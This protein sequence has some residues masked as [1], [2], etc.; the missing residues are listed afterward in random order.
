MGVFRRM[1]A[2]GNR[3]KLGREI[4]D[5]LREHMRMRVDRDVASG[6]SPDEAIRRARLRF[7]NPTVV[8]ERVNAEDAAL[9]LDSFFRD[10]RYAVRGFV[11]SPGFTIVAVLTLALG[12]G[13]NTAVFQL[14]DAVRLRSLP[15]QNPKELVE[16]RIVGGN[17]GFGIND[18]MFSNFTIPMWQ[19]VRRHHDPFSDIAA[20]RATDVLAGKLTDGKRV[21]GLEVSGDF[22]NLLGVAP[23]QGRLIEPQDE[24]GCE[25]SGVVVSYP[26]WKSQ[27][28]GQAI[29]PKTT[30]IMD[31]RTVQVL[32]VTQP[33]FFGL[34]V[35]DSFDIAFPT[36]TPPNP[37]REVFF[38]GVMG[39]LKPGWTMDRAS[40]YFGSLSSGIFEETVPTGYDA[41]AVKLYK[42]FRLGAY[43]AGGG[44]SYLRDAYDSSLQLLLA[45][46]GLVLLIACANLANLML[47]RASARQR[48]MAIRMA[49][50][51]SRARLLRQLLIGSSL[52]AISGAAIG[53]ALAQPLSR[54]LIASLNTSQSAIHLSIV[55]D[56]RVLLFAAAV[57]MLTCVVFGT[58]PA[59]RGT[60]VDPIASLKS[61]ERGVAGGR[62]RFSVQRF[63]VVTQIAVS[64]VLLVG[65]LLFVRSYRNLLTL[66]PGMRESG[67]TVGY[68]NYYSMNIKQE[69]EA[70]FKRQLVED[71]RSVPGVENVAA[72]TNVP[73]SGST[74]SHGVRVDGVEGGSRFTY[75]SPSYFATMGIPIVTGRGFTAMDTT[76]AP[77]VLI[78]N[79][80]FAQK[81]FAKT[82]PLGR[83]VQVMPEPQYPART[84]EVVGTIPDTKYNGLR[85][86]PEPI[87]FVPMDQLP[88]TAQGPGVGMMIATQDGPAAIAAVR[89]A[90]AAKYPDMVLQFFN[91][92]QGIRDN[93]VG[94]RMMAMLSGFFGV[95][96]ALLVVI[97]L[98]GVLSYFITQRR[99]EIG[100]R[101]A[102]GADRGR[103]VGLV[104]RDTAAMLA[105]GLVLGT[106]LALVAGRGASSM[107]FGLQAYDAA[108]LTFAALLLAAIAVLASLLPA[109]KASRL[110]PVDALRCE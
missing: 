88:T 80:A 31:G 91:F 47:A 12:I 42:S 2:L 101:I 7:G 60:R 44:V 78:V 23:W 95:L 73:L 5:E 18:G 51:A 103:V 28:G 72:T 21:H 14:L 48:E 25:P 87:A 58:I 4:D 24:A 98:Y 43:P 41:Q 62:E 32:G 61:G 52:L 102:L 81:Y 56:W 1:W 64:M 96:A 82:Q 45:I 75:A 57:A 94:E 97:G 70:V 110:N 8:K 74:W 100:I 76:E 79:Q 77:H 69:N 13:A 55:T 15:I 108:T 9:G 20:W 84:Y 34:I 10:L 37:R 46:T 65:A 30:T 71:V 107:L 89:H 35:G 106:G 11:K 38:F 93:L 54:L 49:L 3:S 50:G 104:L 36:C 19:E 66:D 40:A 105:I 33:G 99:N 67:I 59:M 83:L 27:M 22:F 39:R 17:K 6:M 53:V 85:G 16:L 26:F 92:Q 29:T 68:F 90:I 109:F 86:K 63:L